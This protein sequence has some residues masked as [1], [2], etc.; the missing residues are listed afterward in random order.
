MEMTD[1]PE[2][3]N[4]I[5]SGHRNIAQAEMKMELKNPKAQLKDTKERLM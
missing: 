3:E 4:R 2:L 5:Q 1:Y